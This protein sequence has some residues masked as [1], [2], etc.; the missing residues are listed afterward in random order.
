VSQEHYRLSRPALLVTLILG[1]FKTATSL[2]VGAVRGAN[3]ECHLQH[4]VY[5]SSCHDGP[6]LHVQCSVASLNHRFV[7][8]LENY[9]ASFTY[10]PVLCSQSYILLLHTVL[11]SVHSSIHYFSYPL[12]CLFT[13][14][15]DL[16]LPPV[17]PYMH[18]DLSFGLV[19]SYKIC[20]KEESA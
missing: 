7:I 4:R 14:S 10:C 1:V 18:R 20:T 16:S 12:R 2:D 3:V 15:C 9:T 5:P 19:G 8:Y 11:S 6:V 17:L 13:E